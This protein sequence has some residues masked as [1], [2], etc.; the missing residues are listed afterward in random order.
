MIQKHTVKINPKRQATRKCELIS[1]G[2][3]QFV[4]LAVKMIYFIIKT[5]NKLNN[6]HNKRIIKLI[7]LKNEPLST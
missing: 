1:A 4:V 6:V 5:I 7:L 2:R 3:L